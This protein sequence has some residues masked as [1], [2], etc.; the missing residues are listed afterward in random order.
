VTEESRHSLLL[1]I[2]IAA[3]VAS[4]LVFFWFVQEVGLGLRPVAV[5]QHVFD[6]GRATLDSVYP[7]RLEQTRLKPAAAALDGPSRIVRRTGPSGTFLAFGTN[8]L[9]A[10]AARSGCIIELTAQ[11][12]DF[13]SSD[14][15]LARIHPGD[16][17]IDDLAINDRL[18]FGPERTLPQDP[19]FALRIMV[20][21]GTRALSPAVN[22]PTT[23]VLAIDQIHR[24]VHHAGFKNLDNSHVP[25]RDGKLRLVFPTPDWEDIVDLALTEIR[26]YGATSIQVVRRLRAMLEHLIERLPPQRI[27]ALR[28]ELELLE[29]TVLRSFPDAIDRRRANVGDVQGLGGSSSRNGV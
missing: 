1:M 18:A 7:L 22:D 14:D 11:V 3:N 8:D 21:V 12:G 9:V 13:V 5:L 23:A 17:T 27:H 26:Q 16:A 6:E 19:L 4:I 24:L 28:E 25:D 2:A 15:P 20:D 10:L 29:T